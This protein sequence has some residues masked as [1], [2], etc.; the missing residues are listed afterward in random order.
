M[1][2]SEDRNYYMQRA[3]EELEIAQQSQQPEAVKAHYTLAGFYL[4]RAYGCGYTPEAQRA[5][6]ERS[7]VPRH[8]A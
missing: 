4:D 5:F 8:N 7:P 1:A 3:E 2:M 6:A